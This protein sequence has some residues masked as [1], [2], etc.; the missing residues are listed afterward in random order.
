MGLNLVQKF[1]IKR[2]RCRKLPEWV[3][4]WASPHRYVRHITPSAHYQG[5]AVEFR[6]LMNNYPKVITLADRGARDDGD[7]P[8]HDAATTPIPVNGN[9]DVLR[10]FQEREYIRLSI[11]QYIW[12]HH[13]GYAI[14]YPPEKYSD[15][16]SE[17][18]GELD[19]LFVWLLKRNGVRAS[20]QE[21]VQPPRRPLTIV[22]DYSFATK[23]DRDEV[24]EIVE[25]EGGRWVLVYFAI[26]GDRQA[27]RER[28]RGRKSKRDVES[29]VCDG[30]NA[31]EV[32]D[33]VLDTY[34]ASFQV[35]RGE[36]EIV[37][38]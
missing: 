38:H 28:V 18:S 32:T 25:R 34:F 11:D 27:I 33:E 17:A 6:V 29:G 19:K 2:W 5:T 3:R 24:K 10:S 30:D 16:Q 20:D 12:N 22:L 14:D 23:A 37:I 26:S 13:G 7:S 8:Q 9:Q 21:A 35:P 4:E 31:F 1:R 36:G 15:Y